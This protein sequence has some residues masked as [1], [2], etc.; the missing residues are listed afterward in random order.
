M[1]V[2]NTARTQGPVKKSLR[3]A[4]RMFPTSKLLLSLMEFQTC[5]YYFSFVTADPLVFVCLFGCFCFFFLNTDFRKLKII[6]FSHP[7][8]N[9]WKPFLTAL[10]AHNCISQRPLQFVNQ[11]H[12]FYLHYWRAFISSKVQLRERLTVGGYDPPWQDE[13][14]EGLWRD[15]SHCIYRRWKS[16]VN[17]DSHFPSPLLYLIFFSP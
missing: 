15:W 1:S 11:D 13:T 8:V 12:N 7:L 4:C 14:V 17:A 6:N 10:R 3:I 5:F 9:I 2:K 16:Q